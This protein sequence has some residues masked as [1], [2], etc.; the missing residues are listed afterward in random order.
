M[1]NFIPIFPLEL[2]VFPSEKLNLHIFEPRYKQL[3]EEC[4]EHKKPFGIPCVQ[5]GKVAELG[6][7]VEIIEIS[8]RYE[9]G[10]LDIK[11]RGIKIFKLLEVIQEL[12]N[13]LYSGAIV[14]YPENDTYPR[15]DLIRKLTVEVSTLHRLLDVTKE[16][17]SE[18]RALL[19]YDFAH[20]LGMSVDQEYEFIQLMREDQRL[21]FLRRHLHKTIPILKEMEQLK[22]KIKL[23]GHFK[24][25]EGFRF[26]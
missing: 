12:P 16:I 10:E 1:T 14:H 17:N 3:I 7:L 20:H 2:T 5:N 13:K 22:S 24:N 25:I 11:T 19:S 21:E 15:Q 6:T 26:N 23:N 4:A 8:N 9:N 18:G